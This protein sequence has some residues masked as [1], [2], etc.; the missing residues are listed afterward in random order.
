[1]AD[2]ARYRYSGAVG[3]RSPPIYN[4]A[5]AS[6]PVTHSPGY[7]LYSGDIHSMTASHHEGLMRPSDDYRPTAVPVSATSY[8]V[9]K[10]PVTRSTSVQDGPREHRIADAANKRPIIVTTKHPPTAPRSNSPSRDSRD[11]Y[12]SS[13]EGQYYTQPAVSGNRGRTTGGPAPFS[14]A[15]DDDEYR[16]L[17]ER[18]ETD[19]LPRGGGDPYRTRPVYTGPPRS[20]TV[21]YEDDG[22]EYTKPSELAR[23]DLEHDRPRRRRESLDRYYRPTVSVS[24]DLALGRPYEQNEG[25]R[26][27][28]GPPPTTWGLDKINRAPTMPA[29]G[30]IYDGAG[31][32]MPVAAPDARRSGLAI[33]GP[34]GSPMSEPHGVP[35]TR[36][37]NLLEN[38]PPR[39][40]HYDDYYDDFDRDRGYFQDDV[41]NRGFGIRVDS[42]L[43]EPRRPP[44]RIYHDDRRRD[45]R[46]DYGDREVRRR[47]DEDLEVIRRDHEDRER[48]DRRDRDHDY[49]IEDDYDRDRRRHNRSPPS[50]DERDRDGR[51][52]RVD[53]LAAGIGIAAA[54]LGLGAAMQSRK[55]DKND[56][57]SRRYRDEED[58]RRRYGEPESAYSRPPRK[59]PLLGDEDFEIVEHPKDRDRERDRERDRDRDRERERERERERDRERERERER[60]RE[61]DRDRE[62]ERER[63]ARNEPVAEIEPGRKRPENDAKASADNAPVPAN[64]EEDGKARPIRRRPRASSFNPNDTAGLA[65]L[66]AKLAETEEKDKTSSSKPEIPVV[67][68]PSPE[69]RPSPVGKRDREDDSGAMVVK[70]DSSRVGSRSSSGEITPSSS[71]DRTVRVVDPPKEKE[72]EKKPIKGILKQPKPKFP[73]EPNPVREGVAPHKDDKTKANVPPGARWTKIS[74][75]MVNPEALTIGKERFEVRDDFVIVLRVLSKEEIQAYADATAKLRER[76]RKEYEAEKGK[77]DDK[78]EDDDKKRRHRQHSRRDRDDDDRRDRDRHRSHRYESDDDEEYGGKSR[79]S[80]RERRDRE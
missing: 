54:S 43:E 28:P 26:V 38:G 32:R 6:L 5:R 41:A 40:G 14:A 27:R 22:F 2:P 15:M 25:R 65:E 77:D 23:Y 17:K 10:E 9:R 24:T 4:P 72:A 11:P 12:R 8:A 57:P 75:K 48:R 58:D 76:R 59:E 31:V 64:R 78:E 18:T 3:R 62:R 35:S 69:R 39:S 51:K 42:G 52:D 1:M 68:E 33:E 53:P 7:P 61:R 71:T 44:D 21:D 46:R 19:R 66:K 45:P 79:R 20:N 16:R 63:A 67:R 36:P 29:A 73:E 70:E 49:A 37:L 34:P 56:S 55:D 50:E 30:G 80:Y 47:S 74:R 13:D 60:D